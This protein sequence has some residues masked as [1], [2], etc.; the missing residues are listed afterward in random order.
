MLN[1]KGRSRRGP[2]GVFSGPFVYA[3]PNAVN[4]FVMINELAL[5]VTTLRPAD[6]SFSKVR[7]P[8]AAVWSDATPDPSVWR[9]D[10]RYRSDSRPHTY[11]QKRG[12]NQCLR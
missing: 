9:Q 10:A 11:L 6:V 8:K 5:Q 1:V 2:V 12:M 7:S 3:E 4:I